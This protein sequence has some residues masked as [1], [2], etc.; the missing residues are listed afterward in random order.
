MI[1]ILASR[2][3]AGWRSCS[4]TCTSAR[5]SRSPVPLIA[6]ELAGPLIAETRYGGTPWHPHHIAERYGLL[7]IICLGEAILG[8]V[9]A[10]AR[11]GRTERGRAGRS[12]P[13]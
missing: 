11:G 9:A 4:P 5:C 3:R 1:T 10:L 12:R 13:P 6:I 8:T 7:V 2:R